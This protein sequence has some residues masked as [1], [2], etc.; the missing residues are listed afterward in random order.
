[1]V[2][3]RQPGRI[4]RFF[5]RVVETVGIYNLAGFV[6]DARALT[7]VPARHDLWRSRTCGWLARKIDVGF[8]GEEETRRLSHELAYGVVRPAYK[9]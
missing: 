4:D 9:L 3:P 5:D 2:V 8:L 6:D 7:A 1:V